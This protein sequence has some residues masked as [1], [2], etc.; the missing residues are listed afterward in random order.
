MK[1]ECPNCGSEI[2]DLPDGITEHQARLAL[3]AVILWYGESPI[4]EIQMAN[5]ACGMKFPIKEIE[6]RL[7]EWFKTPGWAEENAGFNQVLGWIDELRAANQPPPPPSP[8]PRNETT[9]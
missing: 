1:L 4:R 7:A 8:P 9:S 6:R 5:A 3:R 2:P